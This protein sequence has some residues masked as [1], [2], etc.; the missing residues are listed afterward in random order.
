MCGILGLAGSQPIRHLAPVAEEAGQA[1]RHRGPDGEGSFVADHCIFVHKRL[2][3]IDVRGGV[4]PLSSEDGRY[5][6]MHNGEIYNYAELMRGLKDRGHRF[7]TSSDTEVLVHLFEEE[8]PAC[9][10]RL[11]GMFAFAIWDDRERRL[12]CARDPLGIKPFHY[13]LLPDGTLIF[14]SEI[15]AILA[16][17]LLG[18]DP[19]PWALREYLAFKFTLGARTFFKG[20]ANLEPGR[21]LNWNDGRVAITRH[22]RPA[23]APRN[24]RFPEAA[25]EFSGVFRDSVS[26]HLVSDVPVGVFLSGGLDSS[27][28]TFAAAALYPGRLQ[29]YTC[30][31]DGERNGDLHYARLVAAAAGTDHH[32]VLHTPEEFGAFIKSCLWHLDEPGGGSTAIHG[33]YVARRAARDVKVLLSGEGADEVLGGYS[34]YWLAHYRSLPPAGRAAGFFHLPTWMGRRR[35]IGAGL[36]ELLFPDPGDAVDLFVRRHR[37]FPLEWVRGLLD[38][39]LLEATREFSPREAVQPLLPDDGRL[40]VSRQL[41]LLDMQSYLGRIFHIYDRMCMAA[42]LENR[43][44]FADHRL[45]DHCLTLPPDVLF[46][47]FRSKALLRRY[48]SGVADR[49]VVDRPKKGFSLPVDAWFRGPLKP[50]IE[51]ALQALKRRPHFLPAGV[52]RIWG[53]FLAG[54]LGREAVWQLVSLEYWFQNF[55]DGRAPA[56]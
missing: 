39:S 42:H 16:T 10:S 38:G 14:A 8:G 5:T 21:A 56:A 34:H 52:D 46:A 50:A 45:V 17:K 6:V 2:A 37:H 22:W 27:S 18:A 40:P 4:Q 26:A 28:N 30:G 31:T 55:I 47:G 1:I 54:R 35:W 11:R 7:R 3:I 43:V 51:E 53:E 19:D 23:Y 33:Y 15:K 49:A 13:T 32:E 41:M 9:V 25:E 36:R 48:L 20:V 24:I 44:P 12:F 29:S